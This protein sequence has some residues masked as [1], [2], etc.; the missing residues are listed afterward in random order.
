MRR[1]DKSLALVTAL[2][3][4]IGDDAAASIAKEAF[5][6]ARTVREVCRERKLLAEDE[7]TPRPRSL[8]HDRSR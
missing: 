6:T 1:G 4:A 8:A 5:A 7:L 2:V 3:R